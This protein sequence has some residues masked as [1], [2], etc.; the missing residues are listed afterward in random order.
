MKF[1]LIL[2]I[3]LKNLYHCMHI[4]CEFTKSVNSESNGVGSIDLVQVCN[5]LFMLQIHF[6]AIHSP[7]ETICESRVIRGM[8]FLVYIFTIFFLLWY[9]SLFLQNVLSGCLARNENDEQ[10]C[11]KK[12]IYLFN[13]GDKLQRRRV[14]Y[15]TEREEPASCFRKLHTFS[16]FWGTRKLY[17]Q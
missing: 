6:A 15:G 7:I 17:L 5:T 16:I 4:V 13:P 8:L 2:S 10:I 9:P 3:S 11:K 1:I 12:T 14:K